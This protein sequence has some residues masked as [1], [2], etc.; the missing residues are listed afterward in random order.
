[1]ER[2]SRHGYHNALNLLLVDHLSD[3]VAGSQHGQA[4]NPPTN[5]EGI[6]VHKAYWLHLQFRVRPHLLG[7]PRAGLTGAHGQH[8]ASPNRTVVVPLPVVYRAYAKAGTGRDQQGQHP[9]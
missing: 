8:S 7:S 9:I 3:L 1:V 4:L 6:I 2:N 5:L